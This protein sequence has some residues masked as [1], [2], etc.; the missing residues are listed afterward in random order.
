MPKGT[1]SPPTLEN[2]R[3]VA[4]FLRQADKLVR[5]HSYESAL[6]QIA[7][8]RTK[9]PY[10]SYAEAYEQRVKIL[11]SALMAGELKAKPQVE[12]ANVP[13]AFSRHLEKIAN[14]AIL[15]TQRSASISR[16]HVPAEENE[17]GRDSKENLHGRTKP[18]AES[19]I[20]AYLKRAQ[21]FEGRGDVRA[22]LQEVARAFDLDPKTSMLHQLEQRLLEK[23]PKTASESDRCPSTC[24]EVE[25]IHE[26]RSREHDGGYLNGR[27]MLE[28]NQIDCPLLGLQ[29]PN[30]LDRLKDSIRRLE[31]E[32]SDIRERQ[33][34]L[35]LRAQEQDSVRRKVKQEDN[36][37]RVDSIVRHALRLVSQKNYTAA[38]KSLSQ[39]FSL[40][41][42]NPSPE[43]CENVILTLLDEATR[44][45]GDE[46]SQKPIAPAFSSTKNQAMEQ[47]HIT[48]EDNKRKTL[49]YLDKAQSYLDDDRIGEALTEVSMAMISFDLNRDSRMFEH[50][51][52]ITSLA[53]SNRF[54]RPNSGGSTKLEIDPVPSGSSFAIRFSDSEPK[55]VPKGKVSNKDLIR[56]D[57]PI[58]YHLGR[59]LD[60]LVDVEIHEAL[61]EVQLAISPDRSNEDLRLLEDRITE[62]LRIPKA[63]PRIS[64]L[65]EKYD[66]AVEYVRNLILQYS[67]RNVIDGIDQALVMFPSSGRLLKRK[68]EAA[69]SLEEL[70]ALF[71]HNDRQEESR[72]RSSPPNSPNSKKSRPRGINQMGLEFTDTMENGG[73]EEIL[74]YRQGST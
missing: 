74:A 29:V 14:L 39:G 19:S 13:A 41:L 23:D 10:N 20:S 11:L 49:S 54:E 58:T 66:K 56:S 60:F 70:K 71:D 34:D 35:S 62:L 8:A 28:K 1:G 31:G 9:D 73:L 69:L 48:I 67:Y 50:G 40:D 55:L 57:K 15:S 36:N 47:D 25:Q 18:S 22:A 59:V 7:K 72:L 4:G 30:D 37:G 51:R 24:S 45:A 26:N 63:Q 46:E 38:I 2:L 33:I 16:E 12:N 52:E 5:E 68:E 3:Q 53:D 6:E 42:S 61:R 44:M 65:H 21:E 27:E 64:D 32:M 43:T 17:P